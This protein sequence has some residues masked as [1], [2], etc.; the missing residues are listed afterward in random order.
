MLDDAA[1]I[2]D[3]EER[4]VM[5]FFFTVEEP[6]ILFD[7]SVLMQ[8]VCKKRSQRWMVDALFNAI[9]RSLLHTSVTRCR[10]LCCR[11]SRDERDKLSCDV[12]PCP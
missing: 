7:T 11:N 10:V 12:L 9:L 1:A 8:F 2:S 5:I 6:M 3:F 4:T